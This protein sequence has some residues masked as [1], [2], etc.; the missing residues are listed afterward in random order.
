MKPSDLALITS[1]SDPQMHPDGHRIAFVVATI[2]LEKDRYGSSLWLWD[3]EAR[4]LTY[5]SNDSSPRWS[6]DGATLAFVRK[7]TG[8]KDPTQLA[9]MP[10]DGGEA[11]VITDFGLGASAPA[12]SP[13]GGSILVM[14]TEWHG[15]WADLDEDERSRRPRR[16]TGFDVRLDDQGWLHDRRTHAYLVNPLGESPPA[17]W[18]APTRANPGRPGPR[19]AP[20]WPWSP[21]V[22]TRGRSRA[23]PRSSRW[24]SRG[25][26]KRCGPAGPA[27]SPSTTTRRA[28]CTVSVTPAPTIPMSAPCGGSTSRRPTS[29]DT[30]TG[31]STTFSPPAR[32]RNRSGS[33]T[34][35]WPP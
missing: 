16:I 7:G 10:S 12:W 3:G 33:R 32:W 26:R 17:G 22:T 5:G 21:A 2:D 30:W 34:A 27:T 23:V 1:V 9:V 6:P 25:A 11:R 14:A 8:A 13:D 15:E 28:T 4:Q 24:R 20:G 29:P 31:A 18:D 19:T 35:S